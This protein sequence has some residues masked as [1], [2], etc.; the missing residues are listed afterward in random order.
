[1]L[2]FCLRRADAQP[3]GG[4]VGTGCV[5]APNSDEVI[6]CGR[7]LGTS[8]ASGVPFFLPV[9]PH[10]IRGNLAEI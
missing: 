8:D 4:I 2:D 7:H 6:A 5:P 1:M 3:S 9:L 10:R